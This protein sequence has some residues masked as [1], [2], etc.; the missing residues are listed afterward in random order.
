M[1]YS[2]EMSSL[3]FLFDILLHMQISTDKSTLDFTTQEEVVVFLHNKSQGFVA[4][5]LME[6]GTENVNIGEPIAIIVCLWSLWV[7]LQVENKED[8]AAFANVTKDSLEGGDASAAPETSTPVAAETS[9]PAAA[10][11]AS[12][13]SPV[14]DTPTISSSSEV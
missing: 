9:T 3:R 14:V 5:I 13:A 2:L 8:I 7:Y 11:P 4:K 12:P 6:E 1:L 10:T